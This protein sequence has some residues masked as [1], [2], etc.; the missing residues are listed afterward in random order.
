MKKA[1]VALAVIVGSATTAQAD[2]STAISASPPSSIVGQTVTFQATFGFGCAD[3]VS[4]H[5][6]LIDGKLQPGNGTFQSHGQTA[7]ETL[8][9]ST[10]STGRH[11][12]GYHWY[13]DTPGGSSCSGD[14]SI[15]Y[16]VSPKPVPAPTPSPKPVPT[17]LASPSPVESPAGSPSPSPATAARLTVDS[18]A[19][20]PISPVLPLLLGAAVLVLLLIAGALIRRRARRS[21]GG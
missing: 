2:S 12:I 4:T 11:S 10:L 19:V 21:P 9:T 5:Y 8:S 13:T 14:A 7:T 6:F 15:P 3:G 17:A 16:S 20:S 18:A 1:A